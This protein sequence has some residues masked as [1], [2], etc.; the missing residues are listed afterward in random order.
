LRLSETRTYFVVYPITS[1]LASAVPC[2]GAYNMIL[3]LRKSEVDRQALVLCKA[4]TA[5]GVP[6][7]NV[8]INMGPS[9]RNWERPRLKKLPVSDLQWLYRKP[10]FLLYTSETDLSILSCPHEQSQDL[11][12]S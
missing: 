1:R 4:D 2:A 11:R 10:L 5:A 8:M 9:F 3:E 7:K 6:M 12:A